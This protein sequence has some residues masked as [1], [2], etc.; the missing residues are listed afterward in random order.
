MKREFETQYGGF[1]FIVEWFAVDDFL[2]YDGDGEY[3]DIHSITDDCYSWIS[4][5]VGEEIQ[6]DQEQRAEDQEIRGNNFGSIQE[7]PF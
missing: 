2:L 1:D 7:K 6:Q 5:R 4:G 3:V